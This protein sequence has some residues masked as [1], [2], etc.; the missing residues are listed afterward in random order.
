MGVVFSGINPDEYLR[1]VP[2][3]VTLP[4]IAT[5]LLKC[6]V[7]AVVLAAICTYKGYNATGGA[8]GV[9]RA[10]VETAVATMVSLVAFDWVTS[11]LADTIIQIAISM[12]GV[13]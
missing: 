12:R 1:H 11:L 4:S 2:T 5:G 13:S 9:G 7:F 6:S 10:V 3:I 8:R